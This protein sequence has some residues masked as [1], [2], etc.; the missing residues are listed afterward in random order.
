MGKSLKVI[1]R[2]TDKCNQDCTYCYVDR[3]TRR[4]SRTKLSLESLSRFYKET[5]SGQHFDHV[6]IVWHGGEP[7]LVG[8]EYLDRVISLQEQYRGNGVT[9]ENSIQTNATALDKQM[10]EVF[11][12]HQVG[13]GV[14]L[15]APPDVHASMRVSWAGRSAF[16]QTL[17][18]IELM[19]AHNIRFGAICVLHRLN[20]TR[21]DEIYDFFKSVN[22]SY[23]FNPFYKDE[24]TQDRPVEEL[25]IT[26]EQYAEALI[27]TFDRY[28]GDPEHTIDVTDLKEIV[29][30]MFMGCSRSC[31]FAGKCEEFIGI[32]PTGEIYL[33]DLFYRE[34]FRIGHIDSIT[35]ESILNAAPVNLIRSRPELLQQTYCRGCEWWDICRGGCSSKS[36]AVYGNAMREDPFCLTRKELFA[37]IKDTLL[38]F[39][40]REEV[41]ALATN[42]G[43]S[44]RIS[45]CGSV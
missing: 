23:Q 22:L 18:K 21:C 5:L 43:S 40:N 29:L 30:S 15:D 9:V 3:E 17:S 13:V 11:K 19:R 35:A 2:I 44:F 26:P 28:I 27:Q 42:Q 6:H 31:L 41:M 25:S 39:K 16:E 7:T 1:A 37:H 33:C 12:K 10:L 34:N 8:H 24:A 4:T 36:A 20:Y 38:T 32:L 45:P 14:S